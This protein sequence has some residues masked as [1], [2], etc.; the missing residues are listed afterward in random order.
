[1]VGNAVCVIV[2]VGVGVNVDV[3]VTVGVTVFDIAY[4]EIVEVKLGLKV[5]VIFTGVKDE[6]FGNDPSGLDK[7]HCVKR[8]ND[9]VRESI[10]YKRCLFI[11]LLIMTKYD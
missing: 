10:P 2:G 8:N 6:V 9:N 5:L 7:V 3:S 4:A 11:T 1:M